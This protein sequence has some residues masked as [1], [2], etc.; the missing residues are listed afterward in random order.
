MS[1]AAS[2]PA[3]RT[4]G[5]KRAGPGEYVFD[6]GKIN[7]IKGGPDYSS[8]EGGVVEG[9]RMIVALMRMPAGT[10]AEPHS[11]PNEQWI[12]ILEGTFKARIGDDEVEARAGLGGLRAVQ[13]RAFGQGHAGRRRGVLHREG[14]LGEPA[15]DEGV[16]MKRSACMLVTIAGIALASSLATAQTWPTKPIRAVIPFAAG[17]LTDVLPRVVFDHV[18]KQLGQ[19]IVVENRTGA[20]GTIGVAA[21]VRAEPDGHTILANSSAHTIAPA[22]YP[23][24]SYDTARDLTGVI[25]LGHVAAG[26]DH[27]ALQGP[28]DGAGLRQARQGQ[29]GL[30]QLHLGRRRYRDASGGGAVHPRCRHQGGARSAPRWRRSAD[31]RHRRPRRFLFLSARDRASRRSARAGCWR[32][33]SAARTAP[34]RCPMCHRRWR[35]DYPDSDYTFWVGVFVPVKTPGA[36]VERLHRETQKAMQIAAVKSRLAELG[37]DPMDM[38]PAQFDAL[39][40][41]EIVTSAALAKAAGL[42]PN[43]HRSGRNP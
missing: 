30:D 29:A 40:K 27:G 3:A 4:P 2:A 25:S 10:G 28:Q 21:V 33:P 14:R 7:H 8:V 24:L 9:D 23:N 34:G 12:Y 36:I 37:A 19:T 18:G 39:V 15:R 16:V 35:R 43:W 17:S 13:C 32:W 5:A 38:S 22:I 31:R 41:K 6:L 26:D 1:V 20:G 11:H 42:K